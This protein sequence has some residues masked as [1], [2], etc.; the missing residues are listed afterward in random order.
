M[1]W[2]IPPILVLAVGGLYSASLGVAR[3]GTGEGMAPLS[4]ALWQN[5]GGLAVVFLVCWVRRLLPRPDRRHVRFALLA[6][7]I[8][9]VFPNAF[10]F[11]LVERVG[12]GLTGLMFALSPI[13]TYAIAI[14]IGQERMTAVRGLG[15]MVGFAGAALVVLSRFGTPQAE[16]L[17][18]LAA[19]LLLPLA[20]GIANIYR[21]VDW[22]PG[23]AGPTLACAMLT[24]SVCTLGPLAFA[25]DAPL[26]PVL[27]LDRGE[28][29]LLAIGA[30]GGAT[31]ILFFELQRVAGPVTLSL[32]NYV[33]T[34]GSLLIGVVVFGERTDV[35]IWCAV[36]LIFAGILL[37]T[38]GRRRQAA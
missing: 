12:A 20:L 27:P 24:V 6:G 25:G 7:M 16:V 35:W 17:P 14:T 4:L 15:M 13:F 29:S 2:L 34:A 38:F 26:A 31:Y 10:A 9:N 30:V 3:Y 22:P 18:W 37:V 28:Q 33:I 1:A 19:A 32:I 21:S 11:M 23:A 36:A 5:V 8:G